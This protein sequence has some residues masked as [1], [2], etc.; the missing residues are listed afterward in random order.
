MNESIETI[1]RIGQKI[2]VLIRQRDSLQREKDRLLQ[3]LGSKQKQVDD[4][5]QKVSLLEDQVVALKAAT[6]QMDEKGKKEFEKRIN[7]FIR[8]IDKVIAH[9]Q[10]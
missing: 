3:D 2:Q 10:A 4:L 8:D 7:G 6:A 5:T 1:Q 9:L